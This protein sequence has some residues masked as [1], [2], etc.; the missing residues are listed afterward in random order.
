VT[1]PRTPALSPLHAWRWELRAAFLLA[2]G[3]LPLLLGY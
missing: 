1:L 2:G 3:L